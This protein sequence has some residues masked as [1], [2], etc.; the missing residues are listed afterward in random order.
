MLDIA[1]T[2]EEHSCN[3]L[4]SLVEYKKKTIVLCK[5]VKVKQEICHAKMHAAFSSFIKHRGWVQVVRFA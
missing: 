3:W 4:V 5:A 1:N 2:L